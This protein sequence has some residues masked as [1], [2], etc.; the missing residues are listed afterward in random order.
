MNKKQLKTFF[1]YT[2]GDGSH[3]NILGKAFFLYP[4]LCFALTMVVLHVLFAKKGW[5][6][7]G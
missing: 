5:N 2:L 3:L 1:K 7:N 4:F 6:D